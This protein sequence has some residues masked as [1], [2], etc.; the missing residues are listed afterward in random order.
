MIGLVALALVAC[1]GATADEAN[2]IRLPMGFIPSVQY[3]P[4][5]V[6]A[7][8]GY[9]AEEGLELDFDYSF[10][11]DGVALVGANELPFALVSG[12][13][14][15]LA[16]EQEIPVVYVMAWFQDYPITIVTKVGSGIE[17]PA[18]LAGRQIGLPGLFGASY[19]GLRALLNEG[20][21]AEADA[22]LDSIGFNQVE[23]LAVDQEEAVVGYIT[24][25]PIQLAAQGYEVNLIRVKDYV[26]LAANGVITNEETIANNPEL[27]ERMLRATLRGLEDAIND[28]DE[29]YEI[30]KNYVEGL[31][32]DDVQKQVLAASIDFWVADM[33]GYSQP[34]AWE[35]MQDVL[36]DM[37]LLNE[38]LDL[39]AAYTNEFVEALQ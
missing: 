23:A 33:L 38:P 34:E 18:D 12:E 4:F 32:D 27:I 30:S 17:T 13:Q 15:L 2:M 14:V 39:D 35:N 10:E 19:V 20:G 6:A 26:Q 36:L 11:T 28:P 31:G 24:N 16:R 5:Y 29:A 21:V 3:A 37:G 8:K 7:E 25:E 9:F 1:G 22:T